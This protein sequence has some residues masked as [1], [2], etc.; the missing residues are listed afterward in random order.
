MAEDPAGRLHAM[1]IEL[2]A[3][4]QNGLNYSTDK[5]EL[6]RYR[7][8]QVLTADLL[9]LVAECEPAEFHR[10]LTAEVGHATP[11]L[12]ARGALFDEEGRVLLVRELADGCWTLPGGWI[13][14]LDTPRHAAEREFAEE[15]GLRVRASTLAALYDGTR[16][17]GHST[18]AVMWHIYKLF[19]V[20][21]RLDDDEPTAG[22]DGE[23]TDVG[24]FPLDALPTLS[25][26][27]TTED[28]L[29]ML[30]RHHLDRALPPEVD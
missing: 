14:A 25:T 21:D 6:D 18:S 17:N 4:A 2:G 10:A 15:A 11:K 20:V 19:F 1:A 28:E 23:T 26:R 9:G 13:D 16:H 29:R 12:D 7:R 30:Y 22:L 24:F 5:Y 3:M 8:I 27:R